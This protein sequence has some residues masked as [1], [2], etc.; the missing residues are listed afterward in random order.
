M[1]NGCQPVCVLPISAIYDYL[2]GGNDVSNEAL[3]S[4]GTN[5]ADCTAPDLSKAMFPLGLE[6]IR[7]RFRSRTIATRRS[8]AW[9]SKPGKLRATPA[10][11]RSTRLR[12]SRARI[13]RPT[14]LA[15]TA[16]SS[17]LTFMATALGNLGLINGQSG[18]DGYTSAQADQMV[19]T[20]ATFDQVEADLAGILATASGEGASLGITGDITLLQQVDSR[21]EAVTTAENLLFGGDANWLD[22]SQSATLQ[23]WMTAF[24][25]DAQNSTDRRSDHLRRNDAA[26]RHDLAQLGLDQRGEGVH[27]SLEPDRAILERGHLHRRPGPGR[28]EHRLPRHR[29]DPDRLQRGR[30][31]RAAEPGRW[32]QRRR[33]RSARGTEGRFE[34]DLA[35]QG[36]CATI[37]LQI[38]Q[39]A[40]LTRSAFSGTLTITNSEGTGAMTNVVMDINITDDQG[41]SGQWRVLR[42]QPELQRG[43][44]RRQWRGHAARL[45]HRND[46]VHVH[47]G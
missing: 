42:L 47:S 22:T 24:F 16:M 2:C 41:E 9:A 40:T 44:Q 4:I 45:Q 37:K 25:T 6:A 18:N 20:I 5:N 28:A 33:R 27:R 12:R 32:L 8:M 46:L 23:Q 35:G 36:T 14:P 38:D 15:R 43:L 1:V 3:A 19:S 31:R 21:L 13:K 17:P 11:L 39:T 30:D 29:R 10:I 26:P 7:Q 34:S